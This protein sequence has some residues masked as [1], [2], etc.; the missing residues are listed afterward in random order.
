MESNDYEYLPDGGWSSA[1]PYIAGLYALT[2]QVKPDITP[3]EFWNAAYE[4]GIVRTITEK[5]GKSNEARIPNPEEM[6]KYLQS[7]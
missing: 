4:T 7:R 6:I 2:C 1:V 3:K 5:D